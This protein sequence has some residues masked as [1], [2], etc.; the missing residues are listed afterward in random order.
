MSSSSCGDPT[1]AV[2]PIVPVAPTIVMLIDVLVTTVMTLFL[3]GVGVMPVM[4]D[5]LAN[6]AVVN[7]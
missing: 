4:P 2:P 3:F 1:I 5:T 7:A 6:V